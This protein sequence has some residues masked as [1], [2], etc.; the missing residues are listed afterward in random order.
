[1]TFALCVKTGDG[2]VVAADSTTSTMA[3]LENGGSVVTNLFRNANKVFNLVKGIPIG[4]CTAGTAA[5]GSHANEFLL[6]ELRLRMTDPADPVWFVNPETYTVE[7]VARKV[8]RYFSEEQYEPR[9]QELGPNARVMFYVAGL[10][11]GS[12]DGV[13]FRLDVPAPDGSEGIAPAV[14]ADQAAGFVMDGQIESVHRLVRGY[15]MTTVDLLVQSFGLPESQ[16]EGAV[17]VLNSMESPVVSA[18]MPIQDA[19]D[20]AEFLV[21]VAVKWTRFNAGMETVGG[22]I[23]IAAITKHEGFKWVRRKHYYQ[24]EL[25]PAV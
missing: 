11:A 4:M 21:S 12:S 2:L 8:H 6:K 19:I 23:D 7:D 14:T 10:D 16:R 22:Q 13:I 5:F 25:N 24:S 18:Q 17:R 20:L 15:S 9:K 1:M 3:T